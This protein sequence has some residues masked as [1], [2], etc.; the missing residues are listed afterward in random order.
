MNSIPTS[1]ISFS[2]AEYEKKKKRT[3]GEVFLDKME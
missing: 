3:R 2:Q 1:Q